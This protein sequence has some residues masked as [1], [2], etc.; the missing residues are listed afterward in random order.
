MRRNILVLG[1][2]ALVLGWAGCSKELDTKPSSELWLEVLAQDREH[3]SRIINGVHR[4]MQYYRHDQFYCGAPNVGFALDLMGEDLISSTPSA[5]GTAEGQWIMHRNELYR[6]PRYIWSDYYKIISHVN[7]ALAQLDNFKDD[8]EFYNASKGELLALRAYSHFFLVQLYAERYADGAAN[9]GLGIIIRTAPVFDADQR[10]PVARSTVAEVYAQI[11]KDLDEALAAYAVSAPEG[12]HHLGLAATQGLR[13]RVALTMQDWPQAASMA[14]AA[15]A[16]SGAK[17]QQGKDLLDGFNN[18]EATEWIWGYRFADGMRAHFGSFFAFLSWNFNSSA[19]RGCPRLINKELY[20]S[21]SATDVRRKWWDPTGKRPLPGKTFRHVP[22][23]SFK[24]KA[25]SA[26]D[27]YGDYVRMRAAELY[28]IKAE[29]EARQGLDGDAQTTLASLMVTRDPSYVKSV[30]VGDEL[31]EEI[32]T[33]R[34]IELWGEGF[35][36]LDLKRMNMALD[37]TKVGNYDELVA[38]GTMVVPAGDPRW[39]FMISRDEIEANKLCKQN[40]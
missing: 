17:L 16:S 25:A 3:V 28:L 29:A 21:M 18:F 4:I 5:W 26:S 34:R 20:E 35:R 36:F 12:K 31:L 27:S 13:A 23:Q 33:N 39:Q 8:A 40:P 15:L 9:D 24:F 14:G 38:A 22:Y 6:G 32:L 30:K 19:I 37:R 11:T 7:V 10:K 2:L 1:L